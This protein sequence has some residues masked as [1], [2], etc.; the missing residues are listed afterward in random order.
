MQISYFSGSSWRP[1]E[2]CTRLLKHP[3]F[4]GMTCCIRGLSVSAAR[5]LTSNSAKSRTFGMPF[6]MNKGRAGV[7]LTT[8]TLV[9][10]MFTT[11]L[12][13]APAIHL[14]I[15]LFQGLYTTR[16]AAAGRR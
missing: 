8:S 13:G 5:R 10:A 7:E 12:Q 4:A 2:G 3:I 11:R 6:L 16:N 1:S 15:R 9:V 14:L